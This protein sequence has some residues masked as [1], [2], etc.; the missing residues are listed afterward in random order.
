MK[1]RPP[2]GSAYTHWLCVV[3]FVLIVGRAPAATR[4]VNVDN[5]NP[6]APYADWNT[7]AVTI[8]DAIDAAVPGDQILVTNGIYWTG[9]K[10]VAVV[11]G[12]WNPPLDE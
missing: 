8:Q 12:I 6:I 9:G 10:A 3:V 1:P 7:A 4:Y 11:G 2:Q 5:A